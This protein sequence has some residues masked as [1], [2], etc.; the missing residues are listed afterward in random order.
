MILT[1]EERSSLY[2]VDSE[3][4]RFK[5]TTHEL[6]DAEG[7]VLFSS[8]GLFPS[9]RGV[10]YYKTKGFKELGLFSGAID[11]PYRKAA[12]RFN[13]QRRQEKGG[14]PLTTLRDIAEVEGEKVVKFWE[15]KSCEVLEENGFSLAGTPLSEHVVKE[16]DFVKAGEIDSKAKEMI[17]AWEEADISEKLKSEIRENP[18][19]YERAEETVEI[20]IDGVSTKKQKA[21]E[22][23]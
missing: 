1:L 7:K 22:N 21:H 16:V 9:V 2:R 14:T 10:S 3:V 8:R 11:Q 6:V 23:W 20:S 19:P 18:V 12:R 13:R 15:S 4:G 5:F 17:D